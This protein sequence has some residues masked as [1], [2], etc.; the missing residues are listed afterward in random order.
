MGDRQI[1]RKGGKRKGEVI[2]FIKYARHYKTILRGLLHQATKG[3]L[4]TDPHPNPQNLC[5]LP[6]LETVFEDK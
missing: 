2:K 1:Q 4:E 3:S 6:Y 5:M